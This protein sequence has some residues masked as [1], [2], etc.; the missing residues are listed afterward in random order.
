REETAGRTRVEA[1]L[2]PL[3][4]RKHL[5]FNLPPDESNRPMLSFSTGKSWQAVAARY[6]EIVNSRLKEAPP[7]MLG[8]AD[9]ATALQVATRIAIKLHRNIR[10]TGVEFGEAAIVPAAPAETQRRGY[11]DCKDKAT[12]LVALLREAGLKA[13]LALLLANNGP[14]V[15][16]E[17]AGMG[18][19]NHAIVYVDSQTPLWIDATAADTRVGFLPPGDQGRL[20]LIAN[21]RTTA[22]VKTPESSSKDNWRRDTIDM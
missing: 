10:Y 18:V 5:E 20:A 13:D 19:C 1:D 15:D 4:M 21:S 7:P 8:P 22:L 14:D 6:E 12:L 16:A 2:G 3:K 11:G 9:Q 17:L